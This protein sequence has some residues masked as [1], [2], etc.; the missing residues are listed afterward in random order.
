MVMAIVVLAVVASILAAMM[1]MASFDFRRSRRELDA[2]QLDQLHLAAVVLARQ[3]LVDDRPRDGDLAL[4]DPAAGT[5]TWQ[6]AAGRDRACVVT[7]AFGDA[8]AER[9]LTF[10]PEGA[11]WTLT[12]CEI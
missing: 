6:P 2:A 5:I 9:R 8:R 12:R 1:T 3:Q 11:T 7:I 10:T 4:P